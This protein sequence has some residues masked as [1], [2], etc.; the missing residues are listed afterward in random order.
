MSRH[1]ILDKILAARY[2]LDYASR[3]SKAVFEKVL[4]ELVDKAIEGKTVS[5]FELL[6]SIHD[7]YIEYKRDR[8]KREKISIAH[9]LQS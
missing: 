3:E 7:R 8:R 5:R 4:F 2:D 9:R 1:E 6:H